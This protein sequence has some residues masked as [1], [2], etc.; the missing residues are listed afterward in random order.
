[1]HTKHI[2][3]PHPERNRSGC[4]RPEWRAQRYKL[5]LICQL[6]NESR[7]RQIGGPEPHRGAR[8]VPVSQFS[9]SS[10]PLPRLTHGLSFPFH[11]SS[12][13]AFYHA[14][15]S[16]KRAVN[17]DKNHRQLCGKV[18]REA[19]ERPSLSLLLFRNTFLP[20]LS[21]VRS[22]TLCSSQLTGQSLSEA[23]TWWFFSL[24]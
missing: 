21:C 16:L 1:V 2:Q 11:Y 24:V 4:R 17:L 8:L 9:S 15:I 10:P 19:P 22:V 20:S 13:T 6:H 18:G 5:A 7:A 3:S 12:T 14:N 23:H